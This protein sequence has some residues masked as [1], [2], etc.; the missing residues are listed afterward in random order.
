[1]VPGTAQRAGIGAVREEGRHFSHSGASTLRLIKGS[2]G[3]GI[4]MPSSFDTQQLTVSSLFS[5]GRNFEFPPFQRPYRWSVDDA[6]LLLQDLIGA[7]FGSDQAPSSPEYFIGSIVLTRGEGRAETVIDGRQRLTTLFILLAVLRDLEDDAKRKSALHHLL[8]DEP[9]SVKRVTG[10]YRLRFSGVDEGPVEKWIA[11]QGATARAPTPE[12][13]ISERQQRMVQVAAIFR[14]VLSGR[15]ASSRKQLL[16]YLLH[17]CVLIALLASNR[18]QG[19]RLFQVLNNRGVPLSETD[20]VRPGLLEGLDSATQLTAAEVWDN[21]DSRLGADSVEGLLRSLYFIFTGQWVPH[22]Q[23]FSSRFIETVKRRGVQQFHSKEL[24]SYG[25]AMS[26]V[27]RLEIPYSDNRK[28]PNHLLRGLNW[29]GRNER[30]WKEWVPVALE[31]IVRSGEN[32]DRVFELMRGLDRTFFVMFI[33]DTDERARRLVCTQVLGELA[34]RQDPLRQGGS[35][36]TPAGALDK[37]KAAL[38]RPFDKLYKRGALTRRT[39][40]ALSLKNDVPL[41]P[42]IDKATAEHVLPQN[43]RPNSQW[44]KDF[45]RRAHRDHVNLLGNAVLLN[46]GGDAHAGNASFGQKKQ[47]YLRYRNPRASETVRDV[48]RYETWKPN[49]VVNRTREVAALLAESWAL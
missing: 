19:I 22:D 34:N 16:D 28:N 26:Q 41:Y 47:A 6:E 1:L 39:E 21:V 46:R 17:H 37:A 9:N 44:T 27:E 32:E 40:V 24:E 49:D 8:F 36:R 5:E 43:P 35:L 4:S 30:E 2:L 15:D 10:G 23:D 45:D 11:A 31:I 29:L 18:Q 20:N 25:E 3:K 42:N 14:G 12:D 48:C 33:N 38:T 7:C 13:D